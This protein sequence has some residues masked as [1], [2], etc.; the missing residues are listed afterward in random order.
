[1]SGEQKMSLALHNQLWDR[2]I[3]LFQMWH[4]QIYEDKP[5]KQF[6]GF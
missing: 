4:F 2:K 6:F 1:M 5:E 3:T